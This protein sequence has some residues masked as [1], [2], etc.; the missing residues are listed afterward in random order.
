LLVVHPTVVFV[1]RGSLVERIMN[2]LNCGSWRHW[3]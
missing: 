3:K 1:F 2:K